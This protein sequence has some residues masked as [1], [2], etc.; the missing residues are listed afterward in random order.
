MI[1]TY[2]VKYDGNVYPAIDIKE[3]L[4]KIEECIKAELKCE[5]DIV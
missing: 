4:M 3:A 5:V 1:K 2:L